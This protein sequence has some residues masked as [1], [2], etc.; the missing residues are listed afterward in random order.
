MRILIKNPNKDPG[1]LNQVPILG[2][3]KE[4]HLL[5]SSRILLTRSSGFFEGRARDD[6]I[7]SLKFAH[8]R[9]SG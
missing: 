8:G 5:V 1:I 2:E 4:G 6:G 9:R 3:P 7:A